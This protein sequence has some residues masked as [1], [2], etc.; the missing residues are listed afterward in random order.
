[1]TEILLQSFKDRQWHVSVRLSSLSVAITTQDYTVI[2]E[3]VTA[4]WAL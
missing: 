1:M 4:Y 3:K 2:I